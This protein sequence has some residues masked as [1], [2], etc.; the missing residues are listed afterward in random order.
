MKPPISGALMFAEKKTALDARA[1][2]TAMEIAARSLRELGRRKSADDLTHF[3]RPVYPENVDVAFGMVRP[4]YRRGTPR[5]T[6]DQN[7][8][9]ARIQATRDLADIVGILTPATI[10]ALD[11]RVGQ[12]SLPYD[13]YDVALVQ[14]MPKHL[15]IEA[16]AFA[17]RFGWEHALTLSDPAAT[18]ELAAMAMKARA[19]RI[20]CVL[21]YDNTDHRYPLASRITDLF[22]HVLTDSRDLA[23]VL[24]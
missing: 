23:R 5:F 15:V 2:N 10:A 7:V 19:A 20:N 1:W 8:P 13:G 16:A 9:S 3:L 17:D 22:D 18:V 6:V 14:M 12:G 24:G 11:G 4:Q 21:V